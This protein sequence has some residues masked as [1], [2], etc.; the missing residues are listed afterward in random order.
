MDA[1]EKYLSG[2]TEAEQ[3]EAEQI[4]VQLNAAAGAGF[5][6]KTTLAFISAV[7]VIRK[8]VPGATVEGIFDVA[9]YAGLIS[10][11]KDLAVKGKPA[12][13]SALQRLTKKSAGRL[14]I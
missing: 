14:V 8:L 2:L 11:V 3:D 1:M 4:E 10:V 12:R 13:Q 5:T 9:L 6:M 7:P